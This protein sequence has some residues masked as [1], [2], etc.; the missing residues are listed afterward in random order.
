MSAA[1]ALFYI[2]AANPKIGLVCFI[3][4]GMA[5]VSTCFVTAEVGKVVKTGE[6]LGMFRF[7]GSSHAL[8]FQEQANVQFFDSVVLN[9]HLKVNSIIAHV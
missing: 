4:V 8:V 1:R 3:A 5:E 6:E 7:G 9:E 2:R